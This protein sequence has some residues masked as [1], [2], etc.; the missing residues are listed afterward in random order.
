MH[1]QAKE[2]LRSPKAGDK[3]GTDPSKPSEGTN[4]VETFIWCF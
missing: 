4:T 2:C 1:L 3:P